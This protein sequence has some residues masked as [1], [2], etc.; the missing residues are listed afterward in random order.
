[1]SD[2][3]AQRV[4]ML[5]DLT[6]ELQGLGPRFLATLLV[7]EAYRAE[8]L[9]N[10]AFG[11]GGQDAAVLQVCNRL[12]RHAPVRPAVAVAPAPRKAR[13]PRGLARVE[14]PTL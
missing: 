7:S 14:L 13:R 4:Q 6:R 12:R 11:R 8:S 10:V 1:M 9:E 5:C 3:R 2:G